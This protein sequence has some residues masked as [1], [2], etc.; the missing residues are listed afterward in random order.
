VVAHRFVDAPRETATHGY[1]EILSA[2][3]AAEGGLYEE[4]APVRIDRSVLGR[5]EGEL[6][7]SKRRIPSIALA[8]FAMICIADV[9]E[10]CPLKGTRAFARDGDRREAS[11]AWGLCREAIGGLRHASEMRKTNVAQCSARYEATSA[12]RWAASYIMMHEPK[13]AWLTFLSAQRSV[14]WSGKDGRAFRR[15][16]E[17]KLRSLL[18]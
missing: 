13:A 10:S 4:L 6:S 11:K 12:I 7:V 1:E 16:K 2:L 9:W 5:L 3:A 8:D 14:L 17:R 18:A 15:R